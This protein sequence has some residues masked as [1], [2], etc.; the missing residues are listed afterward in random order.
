MR[1]R[2][3]LLDDN[4]T[5]RGIISDILSGEY[6]VTE[7]NDSDK[8]KHY[9]ENYRNELAAVLVNLLMSQDD[10][11]ALLKSIQEL[12]WH[13]EFPVLVIMGNNSVTLE[14]RLFEYGISECIRR[15]FDANLIRLK[16]RN[17]VS[18]F[19]YQNKL[20][21]V[22]E[23][24]SA[25]LKLQNNM[26]RTQAELLKRRN[27]NIIALVGT[28]VEYRDFE[29]GEHINRVKKYT[30]LL[31]NELMIK[32]PEYG[33]TE[34]KVNVIVAASP[35]HDI[36]KIVIPNQILQKPGKLTPE[37]YEYMKSHTLSGCEI[38]ENLNDLWSDEY[39]RVSMEICHYHHE[40][41]DGKGYPEGL[42][43]EQIPISAQI[44]SVSDVYDALVHERVYK[45]A[46]PK[47]KAYEMIVNGECG[48]F[49]PHMLECLR[50]CREKMESVA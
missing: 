5:N 27:D 23:R 19:E 38:L 4:V 24:Q 14:K 16:I 9:A 48:V 20:K 40:R 34:E 41:Y 1:D 42:S 33:L 10:D 39:K 32:F 7:V 49:S 45:A 28:L 11:C 6:R 17:M 36:G 37:E 31:A 29:S 43:G 35:L 22:I 18:L 12:E 26:L 44:V 46:I 13:N 25:R 47:D 30:E 8:L 50:G 2:I 15:P 21:E 3:L